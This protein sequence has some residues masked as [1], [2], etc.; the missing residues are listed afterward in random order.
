[1]SAFPPMARAI[2]LI[3][4]GMTQQSFAAMLKVSQGTI[5]KYESGQ[6]TPRAGILLRIARA[7]GLTLEDLVENRW[8][9]RLSSAAQA[10]GPATGGNVERHPLAAVHKALENE[11]GDVESRNRLVSLL[12]DLARAVLRQR[13]PARRAALIRKMDQLLREANEGAA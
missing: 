2:R 5:A 4:G 7:G 1:M 13:N 8:D 6:A 12:G 3:R 10:P 11:G 9:T